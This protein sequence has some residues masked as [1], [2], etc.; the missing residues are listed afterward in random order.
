MSWSAKTQYI[1]ACKSCCVLCIFKA[2]CRFTSHN[3]TSEV[4]DGVQGSWQS[5]DGSPADTKGSNLRKLRTNITRSCLVPKLSTPVPPSFAL[6]LPKPHDKYFSAYQSL[7]S[8][9]VQAHD[10]HLSR[11]A[12]SSDVVHVKSPQRASMKA[13]ALTLQQVLCMQHHESLARKAM[14]LW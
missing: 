12:T 8:V 11:G 4:L 7:L 2:C 6:T 13:V 5:D 3:Q 1:S 9:S 10:P 14:S